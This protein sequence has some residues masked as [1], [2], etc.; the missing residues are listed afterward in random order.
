M[1]ES[2]FCGEGQLRTI[3]LEQKQKQFPP[4]LHMVLA[5]N[6]PCCSLRRKM[7]LLSKGPCFALPSENAIVCSE[8]VR[9]YKW[10][11]SH[12]TRKTEEV[13]C[14]LR[15]DR[16][17]L[18]WNNVRAELQCLQHHLLGTELEKQPF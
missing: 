13:F 16:T 7:R 10:S 6:T 1:A 17:A 4:H 9:L 18:P 14:P 5:L 8:T 11:V 2:L 15:K 3:R 12:D